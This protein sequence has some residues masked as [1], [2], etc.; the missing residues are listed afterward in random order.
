MQRKLTVLQFHLI[1]P[2]MVE[3][4]FWYTCFTKTKNFLFNIAPIH[5]YFP[6][7]IF[8]TLI[9]QLQFFIINH[10]PNYNIASHLSFESLETIIN[11][12]LT[13]CIINGGLSTPIMAK[14]YMK[15][16]NM[17]YVSYDNGAHHISLIEKY[18]TCNN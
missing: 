3:K 5:L 6:L 15:N 18:P 7:T 9:F 16:N 14:V 2:Y 10:I 1:D 17:Q 13:L 8:L 4:R 11:R 12:L